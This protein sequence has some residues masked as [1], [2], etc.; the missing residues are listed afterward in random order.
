[1]VRIIAECGKNWIISEQPESLEVSLFRAKNLTKQAKEAGATICK[2]QCH[3]FED[4]QNKRNEKRHDWIKRNEKG[5]PYK[6]FWIPLK[7]YHDKLGV[8]FLC[9]PMSKMAAEKV[10]DLVDEWKVGSADLTDFGMLSYIAGTKKPVI[11]STGM[12]DIPQIKQAIDIL[13]SHG[14]KITLVHCISIYPCPEDK[15]NLNTIRFFKHGFPKYKVGFS[16]HSLS[17]W[18]PAIAVA[19]QVKIIE[20]HFTLSRD[21]YG[22]D[23]KTSLLPEE[24]KE[25]VSNIRRVETMLGTEDK[26]LLE[27]EQ[28]YWKNFRV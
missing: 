14:S 12:S 3:V 24:F 11:L 8:Q 25:M 9:T 1:M 27:E 28:E 5:T 22:P 19:M 4:E 23:H 13:T 21:A 2:W 20:K 6:E 17:T 7:K 16:D 10:N 26:I 15:L 18:S